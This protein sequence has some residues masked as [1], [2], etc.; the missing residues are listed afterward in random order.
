MR[1]L[2]CR[3]TSRD[4]HA[5]CAAA[6]TLYQGCR[7]ASKDQHYREEFARLTAAAQLEYRVAC[8]RDGPPGVK[9]TYVQDLIA[10][11]A[12]RIWEL[13]GVRGAWVY[14]SGYV[15]TFVPRRHAS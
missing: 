4:S 3:V 2:P 12:E 10:E 15:R 11:D 6:N 14:I 7:S 13:V 1:W 8:S 9:R 5:C